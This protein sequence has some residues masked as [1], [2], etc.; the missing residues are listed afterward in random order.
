MESGEA[1]TPQPEQPEQ[2]RS[3][4]YGWYIVGA[5]AAALIFWGC[6]TALSDDDSAI[7]SDPDGRYTGS[8]TLGEAFCNDLR[9]GASPFQ[10]LSP[11][12]RDGT[13]TAQKAADLAYGWAANDCPDQL[14]TNEALRGYLDGMGINPDA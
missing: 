6:M 11:K 10:I 1:H 3:G 2:T 12:V 14:A 13:Y 5:L 4:G 8:L 7:D 9:A